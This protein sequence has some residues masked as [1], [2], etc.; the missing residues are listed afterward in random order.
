MAVHYPVGHPSE[1]TIGYVID[2]FGSPFYRATDFEGTGAQP[3]TTVVPEASDVSMGHDGSAVRGLRS[4]ESISALTLTSGWANLP[5][6]HSPPLATKFTL[7]T[8]LDGQAKVFH[9]LALD[10]RGAGYDRILICRSQNGNNLTASA[11]LGDW[12]QLGDGEQR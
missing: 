12:E 2:D 11:S 7:S 5:A 3:Y 10:S 4:V 1:A 8:R 6:S 9:L